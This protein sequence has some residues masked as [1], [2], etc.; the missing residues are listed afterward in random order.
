[1]P[2]THV[3]IQL[4]SGGGDDVLPTKIGTAGFPRERPKV[5]RSI[6][7]KSGAEP[8]PGIERVYLA[9]ADHGDGEGIFTIAGPRGERVPVVAINAK[10]LSVLREYARELAISSGFTVSIICFTNRSLHETFPPVATA[11]G[12]NS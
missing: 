4:Q 11:D 7:R 10:G 1:M 2:A 6:R 12:E 5:R 8:L 9:V 3:A